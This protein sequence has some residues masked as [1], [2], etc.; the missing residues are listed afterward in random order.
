LSDRQGLSDLQGQSAPTGE[1]WYADPQQHGLDRY[2]LGT[3]WSSQTRP[4]NVW[5][6]GPITPPGAPGPPRSKRT[7][8]LVVAAAAAVVV[9]A[10]AVVTIAVSGGGKAKTSVT[11]STGSAG[12]VTGSTGQGAAVASSGHGGFSGAPATS[13]QLATQLLTLA[14]LPAGW[15]ITNNPSASSAGAGAGSINGCTVPN[16]HSAEAGRAEASFQGGAAGIPSAA[17]TLASFAGNAATTNYQ[18]A[19]SSLDACKTFSIPSG[20]KTYQGTVAPLSLG[21]SFGSASSAW[22]LGV[23]ADG[24]TFGIDAVFVQ[25]G[26]EDMSITYFGLGAPDLSTLRSLVAKAVAN[27]PGS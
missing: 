17:E 23:D 12:Q 2:W 18:T 7:R 13:R 1:G 15:S 11:T 10:A 14:D 19:K 20:G 5:D 16:F 24:F 3:R 8:N 4:A 22:Q 9:V 25:K 27:M 21:Q 26:R 6:R